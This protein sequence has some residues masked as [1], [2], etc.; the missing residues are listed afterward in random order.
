MKIS[1]LLPF[2]EN[3][4]PEYAGAVSLYIDQITKKSAYKRNIIVYGST[5]YK[6]KLSTKYQ[7]IYIEKLFFQSNQIKYIKRF[8]EVHKKDPSDLIEVHNRPLYLKELFKNLNSEFIFHF[9][10]DPLAMNGSK[11]ISERISMIN[12]CKKIIFCSN[13]VKNQFIKNIILSEADKKKLLV[14]EHSID[15]KKLDLSKKKKI[16]TFV[17]RL[18]KAKGYDLFG[19]ATLN[20]LKKYKDWEVNV[21][22]DEPREILTYSHKN[23]KT[24]GFLNHKK[25]LELYERTSIAITCSRWNEPFGRTSM[26]ASSRGCAVIVTNRGGLKETVTDAIILNDLKIKTLFTEIEKLILNKKKRI[27]LQ[28]KSSKNFFLTHELIAKKT[29]DYR[30]KV[31][32]DQLGLLNINS[33]TCLKILHVTNFNY[34]FD[35]RLFYNTGKRINNGFI[36]LG[37]AVLEFSDRDI[38]HDNKKIHDLKGSISLN[39]KLIITCDNFKPDLIVLGHAD[40]I[41]KPT[42]AAIQKKYPYIKFCQWFLDPLNKMGPD[43]LRNKSRL[44]EKSS[45]MDANFLTTSP[46]ALD[47]TF[48]KDKSFFMPNPSDRALDNLNIYN[49]DC[50]K[51]VFFAMSHGVHR[52]VL[53]D[54]KYDE[55]DIVLKKITKNQKIITDF[56]GYSNKQ[57][58]WAQNF[59]DVIS[60]CKMGLNLSRGKPLKYY[61]SDRI[62]QFMGN[63]MLTLIHSGTKYNHFFDNSEMV[64]YKND[65][66]LID[67]IL[68]YKRDD[69]QRKKIAQKGQKKYNKYF[70]S[71]KVA[72]Y[73]INKTFDLKNKNKF[74]WS[75]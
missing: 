69:K 9:H 47:F 19:E 75:K 18:N 73:I 74:I 7:N 20:I 12:K 26:E 52:G 4:S 24:L 6:K 5:H 61:S 72:E 42:I 53:K 67:K 3:F 40:K 66:D 51:D 45:Y 38:I 58:V 14:I 55:R 21:V 1:I 8:I 36:Q 60:N 57:P 16:I 37:H 32:T 48:E 17:G 65:N 23:F 50:E 59:L 2:K 35:G 10:N 49:N 28:K 71:V 34:R 33:D 39:N 31:L 70:N 22:G 43:Y 30:K 54:G 27:N 15:K 41:S 13:W 44:L 56:Y 64:F 25:V 29:D 11:L 68:K 63:G 46:D 62:A